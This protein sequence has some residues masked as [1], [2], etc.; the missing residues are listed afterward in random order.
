MTTSFP[1]LKRMGHLS[2]F[3]KC[4]AMVAVIAALVAGLVTINSQALLQKV[5]ADGLRALALDGTQGVAR[6]VSGAIKFGKTAVINTGLA[7]L[8]TRAGDKFAGGLAYDLNG[9]SVAQIGDLT[10]E[11]RKVL[12][13][14]AARTATSGKIEADKSGMAVAA[15]A[16]FGDKGDR[17]GVV[18]M[19]WSM[20]A[21]EATLRAQHERL[22]LLAVLVFAALLAA[23]AWFLHHAL[24]LPMRNLAQ[25]MDT[26]ANADYDTVV[27]MV[28]RPD[29][30]GRIAQA[31]DVMRHGLAMAAADRARHEEEAECQKRVV[32][33]LSI[34]LQK[35]AA[36][37]LTCRLPKDFPESYRQ[38]HDDFNAALAQLG[39]ALRAV[40]NTAQQIGLGADDISRQ[41]GNLSQRTENQAATLEQTAA[42][43][44]ELT[45]N[46][47]A[48]ATGARQVEQ[49][50]QQAQ[51]EAGQSGTVVES[52]VGAMKEIAKFS[53]QIST[54]IGVIDDI[55]FQTNL[56]ALNAGVEAARAGEAGRGFAVVAS[57][58]RALAQRSSEA[59]REIKALITGSAQQ[60]ATGVDLVGRAGE[61][62]AGIASRVQNI[63]SL[64]GAIAAGA[65]AQSSSLN[66]INIGVAQLDQVTQ[67][68]ASMVQKAT[69]ASEM[70]SDQARELVELVSRFRTD[71]GQE[72]G[73]APRQKASGWA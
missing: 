73:A 32:Q 11:Q 58:V 21:L 29:E 41:S 24:R 13:D 10:A 6:E 56:L 19:L 20:S 34:G 9:A 47:T 61:A 35:L 8:A 68:N 46:V 40:I 38:V 28:Q 48:A 53:G 42:A 25:A 54:I 55:A 17:T 3:G 45:A 65:G 57:E 71:A 67:Q 50:V 1:S 36:G 69:A 70:L 33:D 72:G 43:M 4:L 44:D 66:E 51:T 5:A 26:V 23:G 27:P 15:P 7:N 52:A 2:L 37:D 12:D 22:I 16:L 63:S 62:L 49:V 59:A 18:A 39:S 14:L 60:V 31:L 30:V 64:M